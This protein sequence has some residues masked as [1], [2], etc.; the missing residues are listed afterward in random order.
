MLAKAQAILAEGRLTIT[1]VGGHDATALVE[2]SH[3]DIYRAGHDAGGWWCTCPSTRQ[4]SHV[5]ALLL[6]TTVTIRRTA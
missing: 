2:G 1:S 6:V 4:C 5:T 3:G